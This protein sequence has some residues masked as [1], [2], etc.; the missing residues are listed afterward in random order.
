M[1]PSPLKC[2]PSGIKYMQALEWLYLV[3]IKIKAAIFVEEIGDLTKMRHLGIF[4][5]S[6]FGFIDEESY[7]DL[8]KK[9]GF[10]FSTVK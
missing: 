8:I 9:D 1:V 4:F 5:S 10:F 3:E 2:F 6:Q 7:V